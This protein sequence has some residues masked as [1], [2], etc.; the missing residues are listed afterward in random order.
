VRSGCECK[1][2]KLSASQREEVSVE[3]SPT[4]G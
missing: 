2:E 3:C 4:I 1:C